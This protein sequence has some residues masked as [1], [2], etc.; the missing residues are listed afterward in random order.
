MPARKYA[1]KACKML[2][3]CR[4]NCFVYGS[5][6]NFC[7][8]TLTVTRIL[9]KRGGKIS[10]HLRSSD[11]PK[12]WF[13]VLI[14]HLGFMWILILA[15]WCKFLVAPNFVSFSDWFRFQLRVLGTPLFRRISQFSRPTT[16]D[17]LYQ[18]PKNLRYGDAN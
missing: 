12:F 8:F 14:K 2:I 15:A 16:A 17:C 1:V 6:R 3:F 9:L 5:G 10:W 11:S 18:D 13:N 4:H 7:R